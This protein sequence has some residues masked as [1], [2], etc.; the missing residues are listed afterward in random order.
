MKKHPKNLNNKQAESDKPFFSKAEGGDSFFSKA[1]DST[2]QKQPADT[3]AKDTA[4][5]AVA[6]ACKSDKT[7]EAKWAS[8]NPGKIFGVEDT[9]AGKAS[10]NELIFW[11]YCVGETDM[12]DAHRQRLNEVGDRWVELLKKDSSLQVKLQGAASTSGN[13]DSNKALAGQRA[14]VIRDFLI[15][16]KIPANR[17][18]I[19][20]TTSPRSLAPETSPENQARNRRVE[21]FLFRPTPVVSKLP[22]WVDVDVQN[23]IIKQQG[24]PTPKPTFNEADNFFARTHFSMAASADITLTSLGGTG[25]GFTQIL[26]RDTLMA[27]YSDN[28]GRTMLLDYANC[29]LLPCKDLENATSGFAIDGLSMFNSGPG[30]TKGKIGLRD[31][32]GAVFPLHYPDAKKGPFHLTHYFWLMNF[33]VVLGVREMGAFIPLNHAFWSV[34]GSENVDIKKKQTSGLAPISIIGDWQP[35]MAPGLDLEAIYG[36]PTCRYVRRSE[37]NNGQ[38]VCVPNQTIE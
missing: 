36:G 13:A 29:N 32:P 15:A 1:P 2:L 18:V 16:K 24:I 14:A 8:D 22:P 10:S 31:R 5:A 33:A 21:L 37:S 26:T 27:Q 35:G 11:N 20:S 30:T 9:S 23:L 17:I 7:P 3:K 4:N 38:G 28:A 6:D 12:R 25:V 34:T 19:D